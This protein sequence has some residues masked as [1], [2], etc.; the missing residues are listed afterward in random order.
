MKLFGPRPGINFPKNSTVAT[1]KSDGDLGSVS[2]DMIGLAKA[3]FAMLAACILPST[4]GV[5]S[6]VV[7]GLLIYHSFTYFRPDAVGAVQTDAQ[8]LR[9]SI[10]NGVRSIANEIIG[11]PSR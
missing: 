5:V 9:S 8:S 3:A 11:S 4:L 6:A 7:A 2:C 1:I 10:A